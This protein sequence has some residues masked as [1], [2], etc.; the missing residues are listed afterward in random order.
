LD[1]SNNSDVWLKTQES[2]E[3]KQHRKKYRSFAFP[4]AVAFLVWY[5][6]FILLTTF[7]R[8]FVNITVFGN[9][10]IAFVLALLQFVTTFLITYL[11]DR[12]STK[13]LDGP[14]AVLKHRVESELVK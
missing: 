3:F 1:T 6:S 14:S 2:E 10:N 5:F 12:Y 8:D 9:F 11:Y 13:N 4:M 7:A